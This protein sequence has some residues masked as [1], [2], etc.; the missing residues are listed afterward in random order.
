MRVQCG[1]GLFSSNGFEGLNTNIIYMIS[2]QNQICSIM[3][4]LDPPEALRVYAVVVNH[5]PAQHCRVL[6]HDVQA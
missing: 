3:V 1:Q 6:T 5:A 2:T 4:Y